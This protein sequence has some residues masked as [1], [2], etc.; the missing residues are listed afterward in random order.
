MANRLIDPDAGAITIHGQDTQAADPIAL[1]RHIGYVFQSAA[2]FPHMSV[3]QNIGITPRLLNQPSAQIAARVDELMD[4]VQLDREQ[5]RDRMPGELS[6]GQRQRVGLARALAANPNIVLMDEPF[7]ALDPITR[8]ALGNDYKSLHDKLGL[9]TVMI[10]HDMAEA[11]LLAD[12]VAVLRA[13]RIVAQGDAA[14]LERSQDDY[15]RELLRTPRRQA[16]QLQSLLS[17]KAS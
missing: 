3:A 10:T 6:G 11:L 9:T 15:V 1:R 8:D 12:R 17:G 2:L 7:G 16:E 4:M 5:Y 14:E 13:G